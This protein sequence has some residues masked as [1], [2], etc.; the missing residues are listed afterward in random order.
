MPKTS[1][2]D[3]EDKLKLYSVYYLLTLD[4]NA[5]WRAVGY[6]ND[7]ARSMTAKYKEDPRIKKY[8]AEISELIEHARPMKDAIAKLEEVLAFMTKVMRR[9]ENDEVTNVVTEDVMN[10]EKNTKQQHRQSKVVK[11]EVKTSV[12]DAL[13]AA[14]SL[15]EYYTTAGRE[16]EGEDTGVVVLPEVKVKEN[17]E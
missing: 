11:T 2:N 1:K 7:A 12:A 3:F 17:G 15:L 6:S 14:K 8:V 5:A 16:L 10:V 4:S 13:R 9:E